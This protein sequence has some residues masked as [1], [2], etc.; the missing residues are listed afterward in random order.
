[1]EEMSFQG[2]SIFRSG[3]HF[4]QQSK[5]VLATFGKGAKVDSF[6]ANYIEIRPLATEILFKGFLIL[7]L[8]TILSSR[9]KPV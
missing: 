6:Y 9:L 4:V 3:N 1:M 8:A 5:T 2:Y 7:A